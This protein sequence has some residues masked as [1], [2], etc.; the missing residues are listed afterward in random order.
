MKKQKDRILKD[1]LP[2]SPLALPLPTQRLLTAQAFTAPV[3]FSLCISKFIFR[4][5]TRTIFFYNH[6]ALIWEHF[7]TR[8]IGL[9]YI[10]RKRRILHNIRIQFTSAGMTSF[11]E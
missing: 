10:R 2:R 1:E 11:K 8:H 5:V 9:K 6:E 4:K 7:K 3:T